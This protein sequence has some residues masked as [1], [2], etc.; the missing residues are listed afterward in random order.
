[1]C[2]STMIKC[3]S[4][5]VWTQWE[6]AGQGGRPVWGGIRGGWKATLWCVYHVL[7]W[8]MCWFSHT[9]GRLYC[10]ALHTHLFLSPPPSAQ[11]LPS[12]LL[13]TPPILSSSLLYTSPIS[14]PS[15][16]SLLLLLLPLLSSSFILSPVLL[17][18]FLSVSRLEYFHLFLICLHPMGMPTYCR[19]LKMMF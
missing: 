15:H 6:V 5:S 12:P 7:S 13:L 4:P 16:P 3:T 2:G 10:R 11:P 19:K 14:S 18:I 8:V 9:Y 1:M 17:L